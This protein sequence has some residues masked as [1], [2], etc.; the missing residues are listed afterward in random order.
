M[1]LSRFFHETWNR[2][3]FKIFSVILTSQSRKFFFLLNH[4]CRAG[5]LSGSASLRSGIHVTFNILDDPC[6]NRQRIMYAAICTDATNQNL[7]R[8]VCLVDRD[9][10]N[11]VFSIP[12]LILS[13]F[14]LP[15]AI[16]GYL[17]YADIALSFAA[18]RFSCFVSKRL[19]L[20]GIYS[21]FWRTLCKASD[22]NMNTVDD[23]TFESALAFDTPAFINSV[24]HWKASAIIDKTSRCWLQ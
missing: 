9:I 6:E 7:F 8:T 4:C 19:T 12:F 15:A 24:S 17:R 13:Y 3:Q 18:I 1:K 20:S 14:S 5:N 2:P 23:R 16:F 21:D 22:M 10:V 11:N